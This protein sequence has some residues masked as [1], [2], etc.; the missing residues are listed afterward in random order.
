MALE[1][2]VNGTP[3]TLSQNSSVQSLLAELELCCES[4]A[5]ELNLEIVPR[6]SFATRSLNAGDSLE[7]VQFVGGG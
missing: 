2:T 3:R 1:I 7:I 4:V 5:V 6:D